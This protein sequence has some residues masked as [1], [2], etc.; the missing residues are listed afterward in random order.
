MNKVCISG[1]FNPLHIGHL[2]YIKAAKALGDYLVVIVNN[3][4]QVSLKKSLPFMNENE[5]LAIV[6]ALRDVDEVVLSVDKDRSVAETLKIVRPNM[7]C[8]G[9]DVINY[10]DV[11][12]K[13]IA[14]CKEIN[15][16][17]LLGVGG[18]VKVQ[19]SSELKANILRRKILTKDCSIPPTK[20]D[21]ATLTEKLLNEP[22]YHGTYNLIYW[23]NLYELE[24]K[25]DK[26]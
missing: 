3:D 1:Y 20:E 19:S 25:N 22:H 21:L 6:G 4:Y 7:F 15:C 17:I 18:D 13:E 2:E 9:G 24:K 8:N 12:P 5:R 14:I 16:E 11:N 23:E 10:E 26:T